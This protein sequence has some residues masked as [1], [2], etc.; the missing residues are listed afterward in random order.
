MFLRLGQFCCI[1]IT[2][3]I[4]TQVGS[5]FIL[6]EPVALYS[7]LTDYQSKIDDCR[8]NSCIIV[9]DTIYGAR[10]AKVA[11]DEPY[12]YVSNLQVEQFLDIVSQITSHKRVWLLFAHAVPDGGG[13]QQKLIERL[14]EYGTPRF[15]RIGWIW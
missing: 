12:Q 4:A 6:S 8:A 3:L 13:A 7:Y 9:G 5:Y 15:R 10:Y 2:G 11:G 1:P 14:S